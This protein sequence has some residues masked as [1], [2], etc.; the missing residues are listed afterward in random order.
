MPIS[1]STTP[2]APPRRNAKSSA[3]PRQS[4]VNADAVKAQRVESVAGIF[5][6]VSGLAAACGQ[7]ADAGAIEMYGGS[8]ATEIVELGSKSESFSEKLDNLNNVAPYLGIGM[9][10]LTLTIQ[11]A[12]NHKLIAKDRA[13]AFGAIPP[14][15]LEGEM[16]LKAS[17][18]ALEMQRV[19]QERERQMRQEL[20]D[21]ERAMA[22]ET[23]AE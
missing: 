14:D 22:E 5:Q 2:T 16:R 3:T 1:G 4:S 13:M 9:V 21:R 15:V 19:Q 23:G 17:R 6:M 10:T 12:T 8:L 20:A 11:I 7:W 18:Q